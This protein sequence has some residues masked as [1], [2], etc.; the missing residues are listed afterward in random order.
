MRIRFLGHALRRMRERNL[1]PRTVM[2]ALKNP[3]KAHRSLKDAGRFL[4]KKRYTHASG[5]ERLLMIVTEKKGDVLIVI[6]VIDTSK[7]EKYW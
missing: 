1:S 6:T 2:E 5:K 3:D 4:V 7:T